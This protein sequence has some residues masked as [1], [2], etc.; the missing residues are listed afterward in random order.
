MTSTQ[1]LLFGI[2]WLIV[3][4][5]TAVAGQV[6]IGIALCVFGI[7]VLAYSRIKRARH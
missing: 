5:G 4:I 7:F 3:G 2:G 1:E 6:W